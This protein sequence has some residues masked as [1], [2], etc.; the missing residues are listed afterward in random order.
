MF[1]F[2]SF[3]RGHITKKSLQ[4]TNLTFLNEYRT[5]MD[6]HNNS[7]NQYPSKDQSKKSTPYVAPLRII[8]MQL[9]GQKLEFTGTYC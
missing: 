7:F 6:N 8:I 2:Y 1:H 5:A 4:K 9:L 3:E